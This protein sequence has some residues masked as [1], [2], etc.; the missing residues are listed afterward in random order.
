M[1]KT[2]ACAVFVAALAVASTASAKGDY[3][4]GPFASTSPD[5][6][7]CG[8]QW[9]VDTFNRDFNVH[10]NGDGTYRVRE[11]F[12]NGSFTTT[13]PVSPGACETGSNHGTAVTA[14]ITGNMQGFLQGTV[15]STT[16]D[17]NGCN[18]TGADCTTTQGFLTAVFG[19]AGPATF[20]CNLGYAG[21]DFNFEYAAGG[22]GLI[23]HHWQDTEVQ[24]AEVF[25]GD[26]AT[27]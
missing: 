19:P 26:I 23:Y 22:Q 3:H 8:Q 15:T 12:K 9:A 11:E 27:S 2:L 24:G 20:T 4:M 25:H 14:G 10:V 13:G 18:A 21:C 17:P 7:S 16:F 5:N 1:K 6:G